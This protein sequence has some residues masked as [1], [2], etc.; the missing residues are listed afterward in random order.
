MAGAKTANTRVVQAVGVAVGLHGRGR[1][2]AAISD[3][4][5]AAA[6]DAQQHGITDPDE[7]RR[8]MLAARDRVV[9]GT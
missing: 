1:L 7:I 5:H 9:S 3:A 8:R 6:A 4:M 2:S